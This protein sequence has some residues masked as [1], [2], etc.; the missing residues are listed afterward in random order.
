MS[1]YR[2]TPGTFAAACYDDNTV[3]E[4][5]AA[6]ERG[7][8][9]TASARIRR[10]LHA[11]VAQAFAQIEPEA[12]STGTGAGG[13]PDGSDDW[14]H[15]S[16]ALA[17]NCLAALRCSF[18]FTAWANAELVAYERI[19]EIVA[20][21]STADE[22]RQATIGNGGTL[23]NIEV[24]RARRDTWIAGLGEGYSIWRNNEAAAIG[25]AGGTV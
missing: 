8:D 19:D 13:I 2:I 12:L 18:S 11:Q 5:V 22:A 24:Y 14:D 10:E 1:D 20:G 23:D 16:A 6:L 9:S 15:D 7:P 25:A 3:S 4:L 21:R 17:R